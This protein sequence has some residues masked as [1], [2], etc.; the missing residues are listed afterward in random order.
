L[1]LELTAFILCGKDFMWESIDSCRSFCDKVVVCD[2]GVNENVQTVCGEY[3]RLKGG[4]QIY[5]YDSIHEVCFN[6]PRNGWNFILYGNEVIHEDSYHYLWDLVKNHQEFDGAMLRVVGVKIGENGCLYSD[7]EDMR[8]FIGVPLISINN[9]GLVMSSCRKKLKL[10]PA[11]LQPKPIWQFNFGDF[12][13]KDPL[14]KL[15]SHI[16]KSVKRL[17]GRITYNNPYLIGVQ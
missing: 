2:L 15:T 7:C 14:S 3:Q 6:L 5:H 8:L 9:E 11:G 17:S 4:I 16:P 12:N 13:G 10:A 1:G